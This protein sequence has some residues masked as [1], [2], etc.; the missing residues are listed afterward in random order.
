LS[1]EAIAALPALAERLAAQPADEDLPQ[2]LAR[3]RHVPA[4]EPSSARWTAASTMRSSNA[5]V[6]CVDPDPLRLAAVER[7]VQDLAHR[8]RR[9]AHSRGGATR[10]AFSSLA[11]RVKPRPDAYSS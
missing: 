7:A 6:G 5:E 11:T 2:H 3:L 4:Q 10:S 9:P 8:R 1:G